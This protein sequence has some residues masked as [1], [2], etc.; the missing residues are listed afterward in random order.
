MSTIAH[1]KFKIT[2]TKLYFTI[3]SLSSRDNVKLVKLWEEGFK[4]LVYWNEYQTKIETKDLDNKNVT[5]F[6]L[7]ASFQR[8]RGLFVLAFTNTTV[9]VPNNP[10]NNTN[11]S[12]LRKSHTKCFLPRVNITNYNV[13]IDGT[14]F[15]DK[16]INDLIKQYEKIRKT[17]TGH[18][19][20][21]TTGCLSDYQYFKIII[22]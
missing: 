15:Y 13:L 14:N 9:N 5:R 1:A 3:V 19:H 7:D 17:A 18:R 10:I 6:H 2:N 4:R 16:P 8:V 21:Y 22:N 12:V 11:N 20:D